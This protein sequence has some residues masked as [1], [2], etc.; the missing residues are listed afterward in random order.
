MLDSLK[1]VLEERKRQDEKWGVQ[2]NTQL[3]WL[4]ILGEEFGEYSK[5][6]VEINFGQGDPENLRVEIVQLCAVALAI[7]ECIDRNGVVVK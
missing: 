1:S 3:E 2:N 4:A 5:E 7:I 6:I